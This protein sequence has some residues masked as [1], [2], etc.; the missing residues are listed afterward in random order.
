MKT[1]ATQPK[2]PQTARPPISKQR[3]WVFRLLALALPFLLLA[4]LE[5]VPRVAGYGYPTA[6][7]LRE[8]IGGQDYYVPNDRFGFR[9]IPP[10]IARTP[11][12]LRLPVK[13]PVN[14]YRIFL[15]GE[16][17][18]PG[19]PD[20]TFGVGLYLRTLLHERSPGRDFDV[21]CVAMTAINSHAILPIA[22]ECERRDGA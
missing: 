19:D 10:A 15:F 18:A 1:Q 16:S 9:F 11:F 22:R 5:C 6:L 8:L 7:F 20:P 13:K 12:A 4:G 2:Q 17:A 14:S 3:L 21:V